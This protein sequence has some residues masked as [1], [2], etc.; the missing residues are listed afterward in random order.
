MHTGHQQWRGLAYAIMHPY[1]E[2]YQHDKGEDP[3]VWNSNN[4]N[5]NQDDRDATIQDLE[6]RFGPLIEQIT[7]GCK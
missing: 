4:E 7:K 6:N 1:K 5:W 3:K 2:I